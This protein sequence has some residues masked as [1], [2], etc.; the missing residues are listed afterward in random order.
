MQH[1]IGRTQRHGLWRVF[2]D[3]LV[4]QAGVPVPAD[5][6]LIVADTHLTGRGGAC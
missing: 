1:L 4:E 3:V 2:V 5:P 6:T